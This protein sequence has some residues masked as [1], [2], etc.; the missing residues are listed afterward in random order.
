MGNRQRRWFITGISTGFGRRMAQMLVGE[1]D[2]VIGTVRR[3]EQI[4]ELEAEGIA[5][6]LMDVNDQ[7]QVDTAVEAARERM[8]G[9]D[10]L[11][12]NA[13]YGLGGAVEALSLDEIRAVMETNF[14]GAVRVTRA[15]LPILREHGGSIVNISSMAGQIGF[16]GMGAYSASKFA[17]EGL[18]EA[19]SEELAPFGVKVLIVE[20]GAFRTDYS[21]RSMQTAERSIDAYAEH[22]AGMIK[23]MIKDYHGHEPGDPD[24]AVRAMIT[25]VR[26]DPKSLRLLLGADAV[27]GIEA[28]LERLKQD[29]DAWRDESRATAF[30]PTP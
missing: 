25:A 19:L 20:P 4:A 9:V 27:A 2:P 15:F 7:A 10:V 6:L 30:D 29:I 24:K 14:F 1:G 12:N 26:S 5:A 3:A 22:Q 18:S 13:G 17:L 11:V 23:K 21:G 16:A 8:G 28:K